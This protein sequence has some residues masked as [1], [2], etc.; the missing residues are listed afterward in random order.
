M[1]KAILF[2]IAFFFFTSCEAKKEE[3]KPVAPKKE[4]YYLNFGGNFKTGMNTVDDLG[5]SVVIVMDTSG[6]MNDN[7]RSG[8][9]QKYIQATKALATV[10]RKLVDLSKTQKD[11]KIQVGI[12]KFSSGVKTVLPLTLLDE[13]GIRKLVNAVDIRNFEPDGGTSIGLAIEAGSCVLAQSGTILNSLIVIS[14]GENTGTLSPDKA[15]GA[16]YANK[17]TA[18]TEDYIIITNSQMVSFIGFDIGS[19]I[20]NNLNKMGARVMSASN[21][22]ELENSLKS[23]L[24]ADITKL[25]NK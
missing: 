21:Q 8:G 16:L 1:K 15:L 13:E 2:V 19:G 18:S 5:I 6:S 4:G 9:E 10:S 24:E 14:D 7:P 11:F 3:S 17:N 25:E 22:N 12:L 23:L 20:F